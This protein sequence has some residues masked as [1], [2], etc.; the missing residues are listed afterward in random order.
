MKALAFLA[1]LAAL[2]LSSPVPPSP[3]HQ[4]QPALLVGFMTRIGASCPCPCC[5]GCP[6]F[7]G[8]LVAGIVVDSEDSKVWG[9]HAGIGLSLITLLL[10]CVKY[11]DMFMKIK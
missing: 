11:L 5:P 9:L 7:G 1:L 6:G 4:H 3:P 2:A 10:L 8:L